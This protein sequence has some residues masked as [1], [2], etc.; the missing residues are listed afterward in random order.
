MQTQAAFGRNMACKSSSEIASPPFG[1]EH[2]RS[3]RHRR[4]GSDDASAASDASSVDAAPPAKDSLEAMFKEVKDILSRLDAQIDAVQY[5][6]SKVA[7]HGNLFDAE[8]A[9]QIQESL[10]RFRGER[11]QLAVEG[12]NAM[13]LY[14]QTVAELETKIT[15]R[16]KL[17]ESIDAESGAMSVDPHLL[18]YFGK[19][20]ALFSTHL[21]EAKGMLSQRLT[22]KLRACVDRL[23]EG[24]VRE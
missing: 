21:A 24:G 4:A 16:Q 15:H 14:R 23:Q 13:A 17:L 2:L 3:R 19:K 11:E 12:E 22:T 10:S 20:Q 18:N 7:A 9:A 1:M 6:D 8:D 5:F